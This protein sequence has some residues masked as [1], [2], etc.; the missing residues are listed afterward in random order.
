MDK[1]IVMIIHECLILAH[2]IN[3][4]NKTTSHI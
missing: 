4:E 1:R 2:Y 3:S